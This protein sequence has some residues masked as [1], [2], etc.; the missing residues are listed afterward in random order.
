MTG[1][2][3]AGY[4]GTG[5]NPAGLPTGLISIYA[6]PINRRG[7]TYVLKCSDIDGF[8]FECLFLKTPKKLRPFFERQ[9]EYGDFMHTP[10]VVGAR[11]LSKLQPDKY[12]Y[13]ARLLIP[14]GEGIDSGM[15]GDGEVIPDL[16]ILEFKRGYYV[17]KS[18]HVGFNI[19]N[20]R[21]PEKYM[22]K[23]LRG[24]DL[25]PA[26]DHR[27]QGI[28]A[29]TDESRQTGLPVVRIVNDSLRNPKAFAQNAP[30]LKELAMNL[31]TAPYWWDY[32]TSPEC[33]PEL[34]E[35]FS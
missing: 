31:G 9:S 3:V 26:L 24:M 14:P 4:S 23:E 18:S 12:Y 19:Q 11:M 17:F 2:T 8:A 15:V 25:S 5:G 1:E 30:K 13:S 33:S 32:Y 27:F 20:F 35:D 21:A 29:G 10:C 7:N 16:K 28:L 22:P 34:D 6:F